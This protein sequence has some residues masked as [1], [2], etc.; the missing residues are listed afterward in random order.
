MHKKLGTR[1]YLEY[2]LNKLKEQV[3]LTGCGEM[4]KSTLNNKIND[5][6]KCNSTNNTIIVQ[7][8]QK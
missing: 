7:N 2:N 8:Q 1:G 6:E 4:N 5:Q 3:M